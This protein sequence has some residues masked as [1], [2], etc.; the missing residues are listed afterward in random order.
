MSKQKTASRK[1]VKCSFCGKE[2]AAVQVLI[3]SRTGA[4]ICE[5]CTD[6]CKQI[7]DSKVGGTS[8]VQVMRKLPTEIGRDTIALLRQMKDEQVLSDEDY[9]GKC[10]KIIEELT[11]ALK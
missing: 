9:K 1:S 10:L 4:H 6:I 7:A 3:A 8:G 2:P 11:S 5:R